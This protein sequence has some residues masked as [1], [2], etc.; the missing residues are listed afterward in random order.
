MNSTV[1]PEIFLKATDADVTEATNKVLK[2]AA[3]GWDNDSAEPVIA[4]PQNYKL[5]GLARYMPRRVTQDNKYN[6]ATLESFTRYVNEE[7]GKETRIFISAEKALAVIDHNDKETARKQDHRAFLPFAYSEDYERIRNANK[8]FI[9][10]ED[11]AELCADLAHCIVEP[12]PAALLELAQDLHGTT[13]VKWRNGKK[14]A[15]GKISIEYVESE[16]V[17]KAGA[18]GNIDI[19]SNIKLN[20][21]VFDC[22]KDKAAL[23]AEFRY[24]VTPGG[25]FFA[26]I[27]RGL[28]EIERQ[29]VENIGAQIKSNTDITPFV[30]VA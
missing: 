19:P 5:E 25:I 29:A 24:R 7:K 8:Q 10:Q 11:F 3:E 4:V 14:L 1:L 17:A 12:E 13:N 16:E 23:E 21:P 22:S 26:L 15:N 27:I 2:E 28:E 20:V 9:K 30:V 6:F 18:K